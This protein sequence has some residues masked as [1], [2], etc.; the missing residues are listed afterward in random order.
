ME[1]STEMAAPKLNRLSPD[2]DIGR[3]FEEDPAILTGIRFA[4]ISV[5]MQ[6]KGPKSQICVFTIRMGF[7]RSPDRVSRECLARKIEMRFE[8]AKDDPGVIRRE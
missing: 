7:R 6:E 2:L 4:S 5:V 8:A 3:F 1:F